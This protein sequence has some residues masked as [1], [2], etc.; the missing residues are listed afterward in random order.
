[1]KDTDQFSKL[2]I[3]NIEQ[4]ADGGELR[5]WYIAHSNIFS[6]C[7]CDSI[8]LIISDPHSNNANN[9]R[10]LARPASVF[11]ASRLTFQAGKPR[12]I[13]F[14]E[15]YLENHDAVDTFPTFEDG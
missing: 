7:K 5:T 2:F 10:L 14:C 15:A 3:S 1:M 11:Q 8:E 12:Q 4:F 9:Q 13:L 6:L